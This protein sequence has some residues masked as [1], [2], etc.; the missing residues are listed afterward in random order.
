MTA[1]LPA[2]PAA[3]SRRAAVAAVTARRRRR[4]WTW[5]LVTSSCSRCTLFPVY[6]M[7][8]ASLQPSANSTDTAWFPTSPG[9]GG[10]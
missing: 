7:I 2:A 1:T 8:S 3:V 4:G 5:T 10:Y 9:L 6:W